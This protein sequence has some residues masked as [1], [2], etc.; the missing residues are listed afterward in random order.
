[1]SCRSIPPPFH[2]TPLSHVAVTLE[3]LS[4][5]ENSLNEDFDKTVHALS[6]LV[7]SLTIEKGVDDETNNSIKELIETVKKYSKRYKVI[8][9]AKKPFEKDNTLQEILHM[10]VSKPLP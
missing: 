9:E 4:K 3:N 8:S 1:M 7:E 2:S 6:T 10:Y 5:A